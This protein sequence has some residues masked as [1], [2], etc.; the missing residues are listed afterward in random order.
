MAIQRVMV[1]AAE[2]EA[3]RRQDAAALATRVLAEYAH[4]LL[5]EASEAQIAA[6]RQTV[7]K[8]RF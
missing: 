6:L 4:G 5:A 1:Y 3:Q 8:L 2:T 7:L